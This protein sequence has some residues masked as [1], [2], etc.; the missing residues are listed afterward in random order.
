MSDQ[1]D[2]RSFG[3]DIGGSGIKGAIVDLDRGVLASERI[4]IPTP[5]PATVDSMLDVVAEIV[6]TSAWDGSVGCAFP[7]IVR[8]GVIG[9][10]ANVDDEWIGVDLADRLAGHLGREVVVLN[11]ADAAGLAEIKFGAGRE[12]VAANPNGVT[13]VATLG[14][15]IGSA[16][17]VGETL[18]PNTELGHLELDGMVA[19]KHAAASAQERDG[20]TYAQWAPRLQR[21]FSH[22]ERLFSPDLIIVGGG[23]SKKADEFLPLLDLQATIVPAQLRNGSG[24]VGA[25]EALRSYPG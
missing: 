5:R 7:G 9:S 20:L 16:L 3:I 13:L 19:E 14:T 24:I 12:F 4:R 15:G 6:E 11:D 18:V 17:L 1:Q 2:H 25:A 21:Y 22:I 23:A 10:A 8:H